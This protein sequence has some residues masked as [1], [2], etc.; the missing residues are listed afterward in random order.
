MKYDSDVILD[1]AYTPL[2]SLN[3]KEEK[4][5]CII[6]I[7]IIQHYECLWWFGHQ[8]YKNFETLQT[9]VMKQE[10]S[11]KLIQL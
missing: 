3:E 10:N 7:T 2:A 6:A 1:L 11:I 9:A 4:T 8:D 5:K